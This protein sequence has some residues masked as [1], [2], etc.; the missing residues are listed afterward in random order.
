[1]GRDL[2]GAPLQLELGL[3]ELAQLDIADQASAAHP[4]GTLAGP[5]MGEVGVV[6]VAVVAQQ[7]AA[8]LPAHRR[9]RAPDPAG[10]LPHPDPV[11]AVAGFE[12]SRVSRSDGLEQ[13]VLVL[14]LWPLDDAASV[15]G[16]AR[17]G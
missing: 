17:S 5:G 15:P 4:A 6:D 13:G 7:I 10:D 3:H 12:A 1:V 11:G 8:Q 2:L 14:P 9:G 16:E